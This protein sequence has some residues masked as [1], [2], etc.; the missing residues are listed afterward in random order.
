MKFYDEYFSSDRN[1]IGT[2]IIPQY[3]TFGYVKIENLIIIIKD[4]KLLNRTFDQNLVNIRLDRLEYINYS[5]LFTDIQK[6]NLDKL[7]DSDE[8]E[9]SYEDSITLESINN[10]KLTDKF[11]Y[12]QVVNCLTDNSNLYLT[13]ILKIKSKHNFGSNKR[14]LPIYLFYSNNGRYP[15][16]YVASNY[17]SKHQEQQNIYV[18]I[19]FKDWLVTS[20]YPTGT[21]EQVIGPIGDL[22]SEYQ[23]L[24]YNHCL[25]YKSNKK[26]QIE[27][28]E[29]N[30]SKY[31]QAK[32]RH[33]ATKDYII[34]ID[35]PGCQDIDDAISIKKTESGYL[36]S[37][38]IADVSNFV[39]PGDAIDLQAQNRGS[40]VYAPHNQ[41][42]MLPPQLS[43]NICSLLPGKIRLT[44][45]V[46][47]SLDD[48]FQIN[49]IQI[50]N[51][52]IKSSYAL[53]YD[54]ATDILEMASNKY[55]KTNWP[56]WL[57]QNL[58]WLQQF[59]IKNNILNKEIFDSHSIIDTLMVLTNNHIGKE[60][61]CSKNYHSL[62]RIHR[63][64][65]SDKIPE[66]LTSKNIDRSLQDFL[67][68]MNT[69]SA[70]Y[71]LTKNLDLKNQQDKSFYHYGLDIY[72]Y[73]HFTSPIRRYF[74]I[75]V[76]REIKKLISKSEL[77]TYEELQI[78]QEKIDKDK[79]SQ[80]K[81]NQERYHLS[82][83]CIHLNNK[84]TQIKKFERDIKK[85]QV[86]FDQKLSKNQIKA[87][88]INFSPL[89]KLIQ[90]YIPSLELS[91]TFRIF[92]RK[93]DIILDYQFQDQQLIITNL[94]T[95]SL[96]T[97]KLFQIITI[98]LVGNI[99]EDFRRKISVNIII[100]EVALLLPS[101]NLLH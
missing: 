86:V 20:K 66:Y 69:N 53:N 54:Q 52:Q 57:K 13:G 50:F 60:L 3:F 22:D 7:D 19:K 31:D 32:D 15:P 79:I 55:N 82:Q 64:K 63:F 25:V 42:N 17:K 92:S 44:L 81:I 26:L 33:D 87:F 100:P 38:H 93:L 46:Q 39:L 74:D 80:E 16:F 6:Y 28:D 91:H 77:P 94:Q 99:N 21:C 1:L 9:V 56:S 75:L 101:L 45:S 29:G 70:E 65:N 48:S 11:I 72:Y 96:L 35:P 98:N 83:L 62:L 95:N 88:I 2:L 71:Q 59:V 23:N 51:S 43:C 90:I 27:F 68:I 85:I 8:Q 5:Q 89:E 24:L 30:I 84:N 76:H 37:V 97:L 40:S 47:W 41:D 58:Q 73:T 49:S 36:L 61:F 18:Q 34:S 67:K 4:F 78:N 10:F 14:G 12:G